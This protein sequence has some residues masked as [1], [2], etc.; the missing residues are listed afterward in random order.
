VSCG[1]AYNIT[2]RNA[3]YYIDFGREGGRVR[4][5]VGKNKSTAEII[6]AKIKSEKAENRHL[7]IKKEHKIK[8]EAFAVGSHLDGA[9]SGHAG[10]VEAMG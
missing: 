7:D 10:S 2:Q 6:L 1:E 9:N 3:D 4:E 8:F 5:N